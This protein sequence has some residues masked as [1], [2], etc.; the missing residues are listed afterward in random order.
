MRWIYKLLIK[1]LQKFL[2]SP[3]DSRA[4]KTT[5]S[6]EALKLTIRPGDVLLVEGN[7]RFS[8]F[9]KYLTQSNWSHAAI[10]VGERGVNN[11]GEEL[12]LLEAD[13]EQGVRLIPLEH[14]GDYHT[15]ICR[16]K[17]LTEEDL[18]KIID[19][20]FSK[21]GLNYDLKNVFDLARFLFPFPL[22]LAPKKWK[23]PIL[24]FGSGD[25]SKVICSSLI[26][27]AFQQ[28]HYPILPLEEEHFAG[29]KYQKLHPSLFTPSDFDR[30][31]F[32]QII[33]PTFE[34]GFDYKKIPWK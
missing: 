15:R 20:L 19:Y 25:P 10:Y 34:Q 6:L 30:S 33:K 26:A 8:T 12:A 23:M 29:P 28:I 3:S 1:W 5:N 14:Y 18:T 17:N 32:F 31:P 22:F 11:K 27:E 9:I 13:L 4:K 16:P 7:Q 21:M 24:K 2:T